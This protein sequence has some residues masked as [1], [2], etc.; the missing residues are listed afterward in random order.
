MVSN[1]PTPY[2]K[3]FFTWGQFAW[4]NNILPSETEKE[5]SRWEDTSHKCGESEFNS[6]QYGSRF[7]FNQ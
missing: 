1:D 2:V 4:L 6:K 5:I 3:K 7:N